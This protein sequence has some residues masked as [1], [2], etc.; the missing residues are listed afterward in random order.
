MGLRQSATSPC[1]FV[2]SLSEG[3]PLIY[4]G[5]YVDDIIYF[6]PSDEVEKQFELGLSKIGEVDFMGKVSH[7]LGIEF[8]WRELSDGHLGVSLTQQSFTETFLDSMGVQ[9]TGL[10]SFTSPYQS[11]LVI[12]SIPHQEMSLT[13]RDKLRLKYQS[14]V[15]SLNWL[16]HTTRPDLS[17]VV[18]LFTFYWSLQCSVIC[19]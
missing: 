14:L 2:G 12:D 9:L 19:C 3:G 1:L 6:S 8:T 16:A 18:S 11:N 17:T 15:G 7:F 10:S 5:I 4:V 13:Y